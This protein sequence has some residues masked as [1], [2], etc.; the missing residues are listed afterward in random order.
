M[1][2]KDSECLENLDSSY[3]GVGSGDGRNDITRHA[4]K[5]IE[6]TRGGGRRGDE[7]EGEEEEEAEGEEEGY[8]SARHQST[9]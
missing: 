5:G 4:L 2:L 6:G 1:S 8:E 3:D 9:E 7:E